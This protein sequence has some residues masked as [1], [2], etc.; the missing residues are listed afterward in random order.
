MFSQNFFGITILMCVL[1]V[2]LNYLKVLD[3][4]YAVALLVVGM[5]VPGVVVQGTLMF[6]EKKDG[7][8]KAQ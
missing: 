8:S 1:S 2:T 5:I 7:E 3:V 6:K 4:R